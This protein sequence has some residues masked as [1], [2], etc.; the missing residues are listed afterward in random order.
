[1]N[2]IPPHQLSFDFDFDNEAEH[3]RPQLRPFATNA[4]ALTSHRILAEKSTKPK[5]VASSVVSLCSIREV[6]QQQ[7]VSQIYRSILSSISHMA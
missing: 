3:T 5:V 7:K 2:K 6:K 4:S 1:M